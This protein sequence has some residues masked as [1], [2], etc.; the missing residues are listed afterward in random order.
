ME[1]RVNLIEQIIIRGFML[2]LGLWVGVGMVVAL[3]IFVESWKRFRGKPAWTVWSVTE[4]PACEGTGWTAEQEV[5]GLCD[6]ESS[7]HVEITE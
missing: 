5:C 2:L 4:C 7:L 1:V 6:G 3:V